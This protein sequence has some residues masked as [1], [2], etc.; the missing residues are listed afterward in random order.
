MGF[1][2]IQNPLDTG[3]NY[4]NN[5]VSGVPINTTKAYIYGGAFTAYTYRSSGWSSGGSSV[6]LNPGTGFYLYNGSASDFT[7]TFVGTVLTGTNLIAYHAGYNL[8]AP[9]TPLS[10]LV[11]DTLGLPAVN[12]DKVYQFNPVTKA[13]TTFTR[14]ATSWGGG[15]Q[16]VVGT[17]SVYGVAE[18]FYYN[19]TVTGTWTNVFNP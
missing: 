6:L 16:P 13:F 11:Q 18:A 3:S 17:N 4:L 8:V 1:A 2:L 10:G 5:I 15:A 19:A 14:R 9:A 12:N 7:V